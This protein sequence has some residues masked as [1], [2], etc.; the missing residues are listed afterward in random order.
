MN[1]LFMH[2]GT[3]AG[4]QA[5]ERRPS[6]TARQ[7]CLQPKGYVLTGQRPDARENMPF[8]NPMPCVRGNLSGSS[9]CIK[10]NTFGEW[11]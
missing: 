7:P 9:A 6:G 5:G 3:G 11:I 8:S 10:F 1:A 2:V 4:S